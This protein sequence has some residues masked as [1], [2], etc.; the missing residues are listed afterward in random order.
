MIDVL[1]AYVQVATGVGELTRQRAVEAARHALASSPAAA[2]LP[3]ASAGVDGLTAQASALADELLEAG[4]QNREMLRQ[5]VGSEVESVVARLGVGQ[6]GAQA[7]LAAAR[8]RIRELEAA[9][10]AA[11]SGR[12]VTRQA[13]TESLADALAPEADLPRDGA[14]AAAATDLE[15]DRLDPGGADRTAGRTAAAPHDAT[16]DATTPPTTGAATERAATRRTAARDAATKQGPTKQAA[17]KRAATKQAA[18][19]QTASKQAATKQAAT[20]RAA[21]K[22]AT[23]KRAA[24]SSPRETGTTPAAE[25]PTPATAMPQVA[26]SDEAQERAAALAEDGTA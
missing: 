1:R 7:E 13:Q 8:A 22:R 3:V 5:L 14:L 11:T 26:P 19:K 21:T 25:H 4:R 9:L 16:T 15:G 20:K 24:A 6:G 12:V 23:S 10:A 2:V 18:S 17:T